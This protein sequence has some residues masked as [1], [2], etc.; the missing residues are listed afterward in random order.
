MTEKTLEEMKQE[1]YDYFMNFITKE[2]ELNNFI[3]TDF[4]KSIVEY[5]K[6]LWK[7]ADADPNGLDMLHEMVTK[8]IKREPVSILYEDELI[9]TEHY[10]VTVDGIKTVIRLQHPRCPY[11]HKMGDKYYD[12]RGIAFINKDGTKWYGNNNGYS[13]IVEITFPY[14]RHERIIYTNE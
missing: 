5:A 11:V 10:N 12:D 3:V 8:I 7:M 1:N 9:E 13:S 14:H 4:G 2:L 6:Q